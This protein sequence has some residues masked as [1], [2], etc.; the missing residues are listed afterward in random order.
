MLDLF[1][2]LGMLAPLCTCSLLGMFLNK[3]LLHM[4]CAGLLA[5][6]VCCLGLGGGSPADPHA[7]YVHMNTMADIKFMM[8]NVQGMQDKIKRT[9]VLQY[10][11]N[12]KV[13]IVAL[14]ETHVT[15]HLQTA[16]KCPWVGWAY[17][18]TH[19]NMSRGVTVL[20]AKSTPFELVSVVSD[21]QGRYL[22]LQ[23]STKGAIE[24]QVKSHMT[25][26]SSLYLP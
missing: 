14:V 19:T 7:I 10:L 13:D 21:R 5:G 15:G 17:H 18:S 25:I 2:A 6:W 11:K 9:A 22:F 3:Y 23:Y 4:Q 24:D 20:I 1:R 12:Q 16:L 8:W 26:T